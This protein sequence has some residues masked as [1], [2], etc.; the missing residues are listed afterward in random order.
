MELLKQLEDN[1][2]KSFSWE[3]GT[4]IP[5]QVLGPWGYLPV[6]QTSLEALTL[7]T[8]SKCYYE[9]DDLLDLSQFRALRR[10]S[11]I[12]LHS[13]SHFMD[14]Q[15]ALKTNSKHLTH[16]RLEYVNQPDVSCYGDNH[17]TDYDDANSGDQ[18]I[19]YCN[20]FAREAL[21][22]KRSAISLD[23]VMFPS[24]SSLSLGCVPLKN[25]EKALVHALN[26]SGL[27][28]LSLRQCPSMDN[29]LAEIAASGQILSLLSLEYTCGVSEYDMCAALEGIFRIAP[30]L[31]D[32]FLLLPGPT[33]TLE[34]W[35]ALAH[36]RLPITRFIYHQRWVS[37]DENSSPYAKEEDLSNLSLVPKDMDELEKAGEQHPFAQINLECLGLGADP[38]HIMR[39]IGSPS[40]TK[41]L[42]L[43]HIRKSGSD[44]IGSML[45][46]SQISGYPD[47]MSDSEEM[48]I[49]DDRD[50]ALRDMLRARE[51]LSLRPASLDSASSIRDGES[52]D[53]SEAMVELRKL[54]RNVIEFSHWAFG[55]DGIPSLQ[56]LAY[57]DFSFEGRFKSE[58]IILCRQAWTIPKE[59]TTLPF[60]P[61]R[62]GDINMMELVRENMDFLGA[63]PVDTIVLKS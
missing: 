59:D 31:T 11:W 24:L 3:L 45:S 7:I 42:K 18:G 55:A 16:L 6:K 44:M 50:S 29:F 38:P 30:S 25:A 46:R 36:S 20:Y 32:L 37:F 13:E 49:D 2:L 43:L 33:S 53:D 34:F 48:E 15:Y 62:D 19:Y 4:C 58:N 28:H 8:G 10:I 17:D 63:C 22:L 60:R 21:G 9:D 14:L 5:P 12:G 56:V 57:G 61:I 41:S 26:I 39:I 51:R 23:D 47:L 1:T 35:R 54:P 40:T 27:R 52:K